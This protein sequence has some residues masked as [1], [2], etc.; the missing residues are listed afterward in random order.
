MVASAARKAEQ[1]ATVAAKAKTDAQGIATG[2]PITADPGVAAYEAFFLEGLEPA[3]EDIARYGIRL[4]VNAGGSD[5]EGLYRVVMEMIKEKGLD[6]E[7]GSRCNTTSS[8]C[9]LAF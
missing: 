4:L 6:I 9:S 5:T 2:D 8:R 1:D 7:V 3:L